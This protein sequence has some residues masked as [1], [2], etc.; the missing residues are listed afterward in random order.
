MNDQ[1]LAIE[2][3]AFSRLVTIA[4]GWPTL[5][6][7]IPMT[8][9][10]ETMLPLVVE[11][12]MALISIEGVM[13]KRPG[14]LAEAFGAVSTLA[15][16]R[17]VEAASA[18]P[19]V[20]V[21]VL[22]IDSPGGSVDGL[23]EL[24]AA[25]AI[26][27]ERKPV[28]A[29]VDGMAASAAYYVASQAGEIRAGRMD[30]VGSLGTRLMLYDFSQAFAAGGVKAIPIDSDPPDRKYK[31]AAA[32]GTPI[33][34]QQ[35]ADFQRIVDE[36]AADFRAIVQRG[37]RLSNEQLDSVFDGRVWTTADAIEMGLVDTMR[38]T[39]DTIGELRRSAQSN[40]AQARSRDARTRAQVMCMSFGGDPPAMR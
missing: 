38:T 39:D 17:A 29:Q 36:Y 12:G 37:R 13:L 23:A 40:V 18:S 22:R 30:L 2:P 9:P 33:T 35:Q 34:E 5:A 28:I 21:I 19:E 8:T 7:R 10:D 27:N 4:C 25:V 20:E 16:R 11:D 31:S 1:L 14:R 24:G 32:L 3:L 26:A 6:A 15:I